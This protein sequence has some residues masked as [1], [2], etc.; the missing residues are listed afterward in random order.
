MAKEIL[1][2]KRA[3]EIQDEI[4]Y[5]MSHGEKMKLFFT[6]NNKVLSIGMKNVKS[7]YGKTDS[8]LLALEFQE[9]MKENRE[10]YDGLFDKLENKYLREKNY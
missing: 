1:T 9:H 7:L 2:P 3:Q 5:E 8:V 10:Y 4:Y 6:V